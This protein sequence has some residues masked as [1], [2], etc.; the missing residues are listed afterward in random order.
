[1]LREKTVSEFIDEVGSELPAPGG[2][3]VSA[4]LG[5]LGAGL[6]IMVCDLTTKSEKYKDAH[7][8]V[9]KLRGELVKIKD[10]LVKLIDEDA[11]VFNEMMEVMKLPKDTEE[12]KEA[13]TKKLQDALKE[14]ANVPMEIGLLS[15]SLFEYG[16]KIAELGNPNA[17]TDVGVGILSG[18]SAILGAFYNVRINL[19]SI[20]D[21]E[22]NKDLEDKMSEILKD[23]REREE[24]ILKAVDSKL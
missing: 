18:R 20:K 22:F 14:C 21:Q 5:A 10:R 19:L 17:I 2:G 23:L 1:M 15:N 24:S 4:N 13:R 16:S 6:L 7:E 3:A 11:R 8:E 12:E 9:S